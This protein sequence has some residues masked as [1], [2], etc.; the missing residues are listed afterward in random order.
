MRGGADPG[1]RKRD[2]RGFLEVGQGD[3]GAKAPHEE[4]GTFVP[5]SPSLLLVWILH[6]DKADIVD[7]VFAGR[8]V[9]QDQNAGPANV[10]RHL[11][12]PKRKGAGGV[13]APLVDAARLELAAIDVLGDDRLEAADIVARLAGLL[14]A[15]VL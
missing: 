13:S 9:R 10:G 4:P 8:P 7:V 11:R 1:S 15:E 12:R 2:R 5:G 6:L 14:L 3:P